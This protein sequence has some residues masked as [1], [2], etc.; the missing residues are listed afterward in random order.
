LEEID[1]RLKFCERRVSSKGT[2]F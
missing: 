1:E 2:Q